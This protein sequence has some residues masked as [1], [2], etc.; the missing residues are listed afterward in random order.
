MDLPNIFQT[1]AVGASSLAALGAGLLAIKSSFFQVPQQ[2]SGLV[3]RFGRH[4]RTE[5]EPGLKTKVP[6]IDK[7]IKVSLEEFQTD[8]KLETKTKDDLF[9]TLPISIHHYVSDPKIV[10]FEKA[11]AV[12]LMKKVVAAAVREYTSK[13]SFQ[14]LYDERHQIKQGVLERVAEQVAGFGIH[15]NDIVIDEPQAS[16]QVKQTFDN[17][18]SSEMERQAA[19]NQAEAEYIKTVRRAEADKERNILIGEGVAGFREKIATGYA[20]LRAKLISDGVDPDTADRFMEEAMRLD[21]IRDVGEKGNMIIVTP[22]NSSGHRIAELQA[23][24][25][26]RAKGTAAPAPG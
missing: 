1:A 8:E 5:N 26:A 15:I 22:D 12:Q 24:S 18:R 2:H 23:I 16:S 20:T 9:V 11:N 4:I 3:T 25:S 21:T 13:K 6:F 7:A 14:E 10:T 19:K 17:V